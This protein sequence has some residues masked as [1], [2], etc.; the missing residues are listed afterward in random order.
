MEHAG[1]PNKTAFISE[2]DF[3]E[4]TAYIYVAK[5]EETTKIGRDTEI[6]KSLTSM[7]LDR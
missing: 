6:S 3:N 7:G 5:F 4:G 1:S 2:R